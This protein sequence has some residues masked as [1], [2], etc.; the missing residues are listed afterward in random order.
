M[1]YRF[2]G[3][4]VWKALKLYLRQKAPRRSIAAGIVL[5]GIALLLAASRLRDEAQQ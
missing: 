1:F 2:V 5:A 4:V 3:L